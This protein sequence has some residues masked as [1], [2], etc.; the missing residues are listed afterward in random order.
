M[1]RP[2]VQ[3]TRHICRQAFAR[4]LPVQSLRPLAIPSLGLAPRQLCRRT[5]QQIGRRYYATTRAS[6]TATAEDEEDPF[7]A[8]RRPLPDLTKLSSVVEQTKDRFLS[9]GGIPTSQLTLVALKTC[10]TAAAALKPHL[11]RVDFRPASTGATSNLLALESNKSNVKAKALEEKE[12]KNVKDTVRKISRAVYDIVASPNVVLTTEI[13][14][15]YVDI[16]SKLAQPSTIP[17]VFE[18]FKT[19]PQPRKS[20]ES[21]TYKEVNPDRASAAIDLDVADKALDAAMAVKD[22]DAAIGIV[23]A[24]YTGKPFIKQKLAR[25]ASLP[26][27][28]TVATPFAAYTIARQFA[29][30]HYSVDPATATGVT[31]AL[32]MAYLVFTTSLGLIAKATVA[33][34]MVR[35]TWAAGIPL[36]D[37]WLREEEREALDKIAMAWGFKET[38]RH[39]EEGG[40]E[41]ACLREYIGQKGMILDRVEFMEGMNSS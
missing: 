29:F 13:L 3:G 36:R 41:W 22:L 16:Q 26:A 23:E 11:N 9:A 38:W 4:S 10:Q 27:V 33:D 1:S 25:V 32:G 30:A 40:V 15:L 24:C 6:T 14:N 34:H 28:L 37:R 8:Q 18:L 39:G 7:A 2:A 17:D 31:F 35:V 5:C 12:S 21:I 20:G 19:K